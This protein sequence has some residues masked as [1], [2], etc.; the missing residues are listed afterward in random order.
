MLE[1]VGGKSNRDGLGARIKMT[2]ACGATKYHQVFTAAG[3]GSSTDKRVH[4]GLGSATHVRVLEVR[5]PSGTLQ[6]IRDVPVDQI[7]VVTESE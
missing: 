7:L 5:W 6:T 3:Y 4:F 1:L 2:P